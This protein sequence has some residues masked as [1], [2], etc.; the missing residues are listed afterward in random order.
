MSRVPVTDLMLQWHE[1]L[2]A[3][4]SSGS[5]NSGSLCQGHDSGVDFSIEGGSCSCLYVTGGE[6]RKGEEHLVILSLY[7]SFPQHDCSE[8]LM[9]SFDISEK[10]DLVLS[11]Y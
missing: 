1:E 4:A 5:T 7:N 11:F 10:S 2:R 3:L 6:N 8:K 9:V